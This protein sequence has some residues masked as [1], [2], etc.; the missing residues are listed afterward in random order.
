M[1]YSLFCKWWIFQFLHLIALVWNVSHHSSM[2]TSIDYFP[3]LILLSPPSKCSSSPIDLRQS[4]YTSAMEFQQRVK[5][6]WKIHDPNASDELREAHR[7]FEQLKRKAEGSPSA[8]F[9]ANI[10]PLSQCKWWIFFEVKSSCNCFSS[11]LLQVI[12]W[13]SLVLF[14][15]GLSPFWRGL[16]DCAPKISVESIT[17]NMQD[18]NTKRKRETND[19]TRFSNLPTSPAQKGKILFKQNLRNSR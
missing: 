4:H 19:L 16:L 9:P 10:L 2:L 15:L 18:T 8:V 13:S 17:N 1:L 5:E 14:S 12:S 7:L 6:A 11:S 3:K